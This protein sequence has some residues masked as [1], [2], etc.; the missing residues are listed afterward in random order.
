MQGKSHGKKTKKMRGSPS[1]CSQKENMLQNAGI[2]LK[3]KTLFLTN[4][5]KVNN[6]IKYFDSISDEVLKNFGLR[7]KILHV[8]V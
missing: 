5:K 4:K 7:D 2:E 8:Y 1:T 3:Q 6:R